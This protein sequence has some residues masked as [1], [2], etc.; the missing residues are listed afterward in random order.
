MITV[1]VSRRSACARLE[2]AEERL[3]GSNDSMAVIAAD[4]GYAS[5]QHFAQDFKRR[6][7][8]SPSAFR[9]GM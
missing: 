9:H 1:A 6:R 5:S 7:G 3:R 4:C 2:H 8:C